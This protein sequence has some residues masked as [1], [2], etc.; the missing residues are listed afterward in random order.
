MRRL[1]QEMFRAIFM[2][3]SPPEDAEAVLDTPRLPRAPLPGIAARLALSP[4]RPSPAKAS[5]AKASPARR[6]RLSGVAAQGD[7][8]AAAGVAGDAETVPLSEYN[9]QAFRGATYF[10]RVETLQEHLQRLQAV[11]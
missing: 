6:L 5:P 8:A 7:A 9:Q 3:Y 11:R 1:A 4:S 10:S 2:N